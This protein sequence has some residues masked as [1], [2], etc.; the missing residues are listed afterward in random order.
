MDAA[1][2][3]GLLQEFDLYE[4]S[5]APLPA[6]LNSPLCDSQDAL[7]DPSSRRTSVLFKFRPDLLDVH[8]VEWEHKDI[9]RISKEG[10]CKNDPLQMQMHPILQSRR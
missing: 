2:L 4:N 9:T 6:V 1:A 5:P 7:S 3:K 10:K 8:H